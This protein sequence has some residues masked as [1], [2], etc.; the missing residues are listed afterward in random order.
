MRAVD[1]VLD[2]DHGLDAQ[3]NDIDGKEALK[4]NEFD[5]INEAPVT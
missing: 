2:I 5:L 4:G 1:V 3:R